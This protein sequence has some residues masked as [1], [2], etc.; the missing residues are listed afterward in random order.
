MLLAINIHFKLINTFVVLHLYGCRFYTI[1]SLDI[2]KNSKI[3]KRNKVNVMFAVFLDSLGLHRVKNSSATKNAVSL[4]LYS[5]PF[6]M[7]QTF[8]EKSGHGVKCKVT[9]HTKFGQKVSRTN[10]L[11]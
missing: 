7:C 10:L 2:A 8:D 9:F 11:I 3:F 4:H 5:P 6:Q 1:N